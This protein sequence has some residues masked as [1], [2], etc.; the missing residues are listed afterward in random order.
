MGTP[1]FAL[2]PIGAY[3]PRWFMGPVHMNPADAVMAFQDLQ[4][5]QAIGM[6]YGTFQLTAEPIDAP[7]RDLAEALAAA[8]IPGERFRALDI[9]ESIFF[10]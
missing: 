8:G 9:G 2:L 7:I 4:P 5:R 3:E 6:H 1:D 10:L